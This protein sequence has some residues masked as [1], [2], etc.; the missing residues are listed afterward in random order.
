MADVAATYSYD[1]LGRRYQKTAGGVTTTYCQDGLTPVVETTSTGLTKRHR[2]FED[3]DT[4]MA[5][6]D[7]VQRQFPDQRFRPRH[8]SQTMAHGGTSEAVSAQA[9]SAA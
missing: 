5:R 2:S 7:S 4:V 6:G 1:P 3:G 8:L 9:P